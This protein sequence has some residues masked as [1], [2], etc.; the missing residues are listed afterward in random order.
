MIRVHMVQIDGNILD[1]FPQLLDVG[2]RFQIAR[3][4]MEGARAKLIKLASQ[5]LHSTRA[6]YIAG[7]QP[8]ERDGKDVV[9]VLAGSLPNMVE[10]GWDGGFLQETL[11]GDNTSG[12]KISA[13]GYRYRAIPFRHKT[14][15]AG[16]QGGQPMGSQFGANGSKSLAA[17]HAMVE[18]TKKLGQKIHRQAKKLISAKQAAGGAS[19]PTRLQA[20]L[21][22]KLRPHHTTDIFSGMI[23]N[24]QPVQKSGGAPGQVAHQSTYTTFRM[25]SEAV[26]DKW[27][28]PGIEARHFMDDVSDYIDQNGA[29]AVEAYLKEMLSP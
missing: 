26:P 3:N 29:K 1:K 21:A 19:G 10:H 4:I 9:L 16:A 14:P 17:P 15:G 8:V 23:V 25:I 2:T 28:H 27:M 20:G 6:D 24:K 11:L 13:E 5:Q 22:P 7:I 18:D 12:W